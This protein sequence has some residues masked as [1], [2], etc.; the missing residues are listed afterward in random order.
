MTLA[1]GS[2]GLLEDGMGQP[3]GSKEL[4]DRS[5]GLLDRSK[6]MIDRNRAAEV[7]RSADCTDVAEYTDKRAGRT[8]NPK[9]STLTKLNFYNL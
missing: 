9:G 7:R 5:T 8:P 6:E 4:I 1:A 3:G 2:K